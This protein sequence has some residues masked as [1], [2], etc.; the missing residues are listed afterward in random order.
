MTMIIDPGFKV[1]LES[2]VA[3]IHDKIGAP[4]VLATCVDEERQH[5]IVNS[6]L[7]LPKRMTDAMPLT[8][9]I[10]QHVIAMDFPLIVDD[11]VL[12]PLVS[13]NGAV[14][15]LGIAAYL[16]APIRYQC[17]DKRGALCVLDTHRRRWTNA[18]IKTVV[19]AAAA[20][21]GLTF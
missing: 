9:S 18:E 3:A 6:G 11:A 7:V 2:I 12:H 8:H 17:D 16:G 14:T 5:L 19:D 15:E 10:C 20:V 4:I 1:T 21:N 13:R